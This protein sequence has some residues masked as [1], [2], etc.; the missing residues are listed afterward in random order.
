MAK[1]ELSGT[2]VF[3]QS[4]PGFDRLN[5]EFNHTFSIYKNCETKKDKQGEYKIANGDLTLSA[6]SK[7]YIKELENSKSNVTSY[8]K[9]KMETLLKSKFSIDNN[10]LTVFK[11]TL[12]YKF[13]K[14]R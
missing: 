7:S 14:I 10:I 2:W 12:I 5:F 11:D 1:D 3:E 13:K 6:F 4:N 8:D 9:T